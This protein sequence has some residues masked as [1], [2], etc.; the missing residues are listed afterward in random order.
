MDLGLTGKQVFITGGSVG[1][2]LAVAKA[3]ARE[4]AAVAIGARNKE[5]VETEAANIAREFGVKT[6]GITMDV[7]KPEDIEQGRLIIE[8]EFGGIDILINNAGSGTE[9][10]V[11]DT[12]D[13]KWYAIWDLHVM[14]AIRTTR[15]FVPYMKKR[16]GGVILN[17]ASICATQP[18]WYE[19]IYNTTKAALVML[20][21][22]LANE[23]V[24]DNIRV[25]T[26]SPGLVL[27]PDWWKTAGILAE[28]EGITAQ[29]Y[30]DNLAHDLAPID[31]FASP[32]EVAETFVFMASEKSSYTTGSNFFVD[33]GWLNTI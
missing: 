1:I 19:P 10:K 22:C 8:K 30:L 28:K 4:G 24:G 11:M 14:S 31:R 6:L 20:D 23:L 13:E 18:L 15:A 32:E 26:I 29:E 27:T 21:K 5:R 7:N 12:P 17:T 9:E 3:F 2:G 33:G 16:G 25:N